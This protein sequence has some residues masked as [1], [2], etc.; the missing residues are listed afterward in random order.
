MMV[1]SVLSTLCVITIALAGCGFPWEHA[2][3]EVDLS[4]ELDS[5][6]D[7][8]ESGSRIRLEFTTRGAVGPDTSIGI[9]LPDGVQLL[10]GGTWAQGPWPQDHVVAIEATVVAAQ[11]GP[12]VLRGWMN[13]IS[14]CTTGGIAKT[15]KMIVSEGG[16][17]YS[18]PD[19]APGGVVIDVE[20][21]GQVFV[22][23]TAENPYSASVCVVVGDAL[24][25]A[26]IESGEVHWTGDL[27]SGRN[28][29]LKFQLGNIESSD[30]LIQVSLRPHASITTDSGSAFV[31]VTEHNGFYEVTR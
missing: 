18:D 13:S 16:V 28:N 6:E 21:D 14:N 3:P 22:S 27:E 25:S 11:P 10:D 30:V 19:P 9:N 2:I 26:T 17:E 31:Y 4:L 15:V 20:S 7:F 8:F 23:V 24:T 12:H 5:I 1:Q 29:V